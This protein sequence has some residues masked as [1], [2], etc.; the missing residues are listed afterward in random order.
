VRRNVMAWVRIRH[1]VAGSRGFT[2]IELFVVLAV[3]GVLVALALPRY[4]GS[5][6]TVLVNEADEILQELKL[7]AWQ[8]YQEH[9]TWA[10]VP[11]GVPMPASN[12]F[13]FSPP[14]GACWEFGVTTATDSQIVLRAQA[15]PAGRPICVL[16]SATATVDLTVNSDGS[17]LR[18]QGGL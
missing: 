18:V 8:H 5:R 16:L 17:S 15:D 2:L 3:L 1:R 10:A 12:V 4:L 14:G 13:G 7:S 9:S 11:T 6:R